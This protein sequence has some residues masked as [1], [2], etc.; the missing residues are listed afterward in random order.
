MF[1]NY[2]VKCIGTTA[3]ADLV[4][5]TTAGLFFGLS[6]GLS[7][8]TAGSLIVVDGASTI[9][10]WSDTAAN[11]FVTLTPGIPIAVTSGLSATASGGGT[12]LNYSLFYR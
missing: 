1:N 7:G 12:T 4:A 8:T 9:L 2:A 6:V 11:T 10:V 3:T 5:L